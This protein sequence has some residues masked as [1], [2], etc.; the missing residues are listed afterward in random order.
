M[1][2]KRIF[3]KKEND[4]YKRLANYIA[5]ASHKGEKC[6]LSW[7]A[8]T[9]DEED[10]AT[11]INEVISVQAMN[12]RTAKEKTYHLIVSFRMEDEGKLTVEQYKEIEKEFAKALGFEE[13]QRHCG[14][15]TNTENL[16]LHIA[17]NM[18]HPKNHKRIEP[19]RDFYKLEKVCRE[20]E[21]KYNLSVDNGINQQ[22]TAHKLSQNS[23]AKEA[24]TGEESY[25]RY[26]IEKHD[27][28]MKQ[29]AKAQHWEDVHKVF[30]LYGLEVKQRAN[31]LSIKNKKG[32]QS[33]KA[34]TF[35]RELSYKKMLE[36][37]GKFMSMKQFVKAKDWYKKK[38]LKINRKS[39]LW[40]EFIQESKH[41]EIMEIKE[42]WQKEKIRLTGL[43]V[44]RGKQKELLRNATVLERMEINKLRQ[45]FSAK[46]SNWL[47]FLQDKAKN[48]S[49]EALE[50]LRSR[51]N[52]PLP[53]MLNAGAYG[54]YRTS[55][56]AQHKTLEQN[57]KILMSDNTATTKKVLKAVQRM[58]SITDEKFEFRITRTGAIVFEFENGGKVVDEGK[59]SAKNY[60]ERKSQIILTR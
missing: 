32:R 51:K 30:A 21:Q 12:K 35:D 1:I 44:S 57:S 34:S 20:M 58:Q 10:Y 29:I 31:G 15:H 42:K 24:R 6:L 18:I 3:C 5:D 8:E 7:C 28:I 46:S 60:R 56:Q 55:L 25:E 41:Y 40:R 59:I 39:E 36:R 52:S 54:E 53:E 38:P 27:T 37:F 47:E 48:G 19:Y 50:T 43:A 22:D 11:S 13:H 49:E 17:Y 14:V 2:S 45:D 4:N 26:V 16:H 9:Y 33:M 23:A